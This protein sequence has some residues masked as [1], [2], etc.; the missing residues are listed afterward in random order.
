L[1]N[2]LKFSEPIYGVPLILQTEL[3]SKRPNLTKPLFIVNKNA[4]EFIK[5]GKC[6]ICN[7]NIDSNDLKK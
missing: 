4:C 3:T 6:S 2:Y 5:Q 1:I 7:N